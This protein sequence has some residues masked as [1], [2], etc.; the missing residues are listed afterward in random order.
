MWIY[1]LPDTI[2]LW[3]HFSPK[4]LTWKWSRRSST[5][6]DRIKINIFHT[7]WRA[8]A[9]SSLL[10]FFCFHQQISGSESHSREIET[11]EILSQAKQNK[12]KERCP[13]HRRRMNPSAGP[14]WRSSTFNEGFCS[15]APSAFCWPRFY[16]SSR[17]QQIVG[18]LWMVGVSGTFMA[19]LDGYKWDVYILS[20]SENKRSW[21]FTVMTQFTA[22]KFSAYKIEWDVQ[23]SSHQ[24]VAPNC[25]KLA[26][27]FYKMKADWVLASTHR[28]TG[29]HGINSHEMW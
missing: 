27:I 14:N 5:W 29:V 3:D 26:N 28:R 10:V 24:L 4:Y 15:D 2:L 21:H 13:T 20:Y 18:L 25:S 7:F 22:S 17:C 12:K 11:I 19:F 16:G 6:L 8:V 9:F 23:A 1:Y